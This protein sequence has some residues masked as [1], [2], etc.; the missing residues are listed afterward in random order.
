[1]TDEQKVFI[2]G[3]EGRGEEVIKAL[4]DLGAENYEGWDG[5]N[6][7]A[8]YFITHDGGVGCTPYDDEIA[9]MLMEYCHEVKLPERWRDGNILVDKNNPGQFA[10]YNDDLVGGDFFESYMRLV[11]APS[12][13][14][15]GLKERIINWETTQM[16]SLFTAYS[17][18]WV[19]TGTL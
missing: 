9:S 12:F 18:R 11:H 17:P 15:N 16:C 13:L 19:N 14:T 7:H 4:T 10:V 2:P 3:V 6:T 8:V 1:M 5:E